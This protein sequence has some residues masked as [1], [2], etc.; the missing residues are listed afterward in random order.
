[1]QKL[2]TVKQT[3]RQRVTRLGD[4]V[5]AYQ[6]ASDAARTRIIQA[7]HEAVEKTVLRARQKHYMLMAEER[8]LAEQEQHQRAEERAGIQP[9]VDQSS[10]IRAL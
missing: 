7:F 6:A 2:W 8:I 5:A 9:T 4:G 1:M 10:V 3:H